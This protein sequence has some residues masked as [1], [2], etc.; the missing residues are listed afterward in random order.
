MR[1]HLTVGSGL[2]RLA[3]AIVALVAVIHDAM[4]EEKTYRATLDAT[5]PDLALTDGTS[6]D[7]RA[8]A[9]PASGRDGAHC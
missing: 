5:R 3:D 2:H 9:C 8:R 4:A 7:V 6:R 1:E